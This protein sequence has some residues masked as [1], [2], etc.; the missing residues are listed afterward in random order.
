MK[1][2]LQDEENQRLIEALIALLEKLKPVFKQQRVYQRVVLLMVG[3]VLAFARHTLTQVLMVLGWV[4]RDWSAWYRLF[5]KGRF[6]Y[7][8]VAREIVKEMVEEVKGGWIVVAGDGTRT[9]RSSKKIEGV[10]WLPQVGGAPFKRG[11]AL[12]QRWFHLAW[13]A[14]EEGGYSRAIPMLWLPAFTPGSH[15]KVEEARTE[16]EATL[17]ALGW[18]RGVL[19]EIGKGAKRVLMVA[20]GGYDQV[21]MWKGLP[22]GV[23]LMVRSARNRALFFLPTSEMRANRKYGNRAP[24]PAELWRQRKGWQKL[25]K[26]EV[27]GRTRELQVKV[28]GPVVRRGAAE[29][30]LILIVVR[31]RGRGRRRWPPLPFL[32]NA[33]Q[34]EAGQWVL[35]LPLEQ[36]LFWTWQRWEIEVVHRELKS[37]FGMGEKQN[38]HPRAAVLTVQWSA[39]VYAVLVFAGYRAWGITGGPR[40]PTRWWRGSGRWSLNSLW[41]AYRAAWW[42]RPNF[43]AVDLKERLTARDF[44]WLRSTQGNAVA[45]AARL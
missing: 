19:K 45:G 25:K 34:N 14:P 2:I 12:Y 28:V 3:E 17:W 11:L 18:L 40:P 26:M 20:D 10:G 30:P 7:L 44:A 32:V 16:V 42:G 23:I 37:S 13:L 35:P 33:V 15:R 36:L 9:R 29:R 5:Q 21:K 22:E 39:W 38:W 4:D 1:K 43:R 24:T 41:R 8:E 31:G 27:R 6:P